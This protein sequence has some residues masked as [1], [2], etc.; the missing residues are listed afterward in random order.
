TYLSDVPVRYDPAALL[1]I[2]SIDGHRVHV[3]MS[4]SRTSVLCALSIV[5]VAVGVNAICTILQD[6]MTK[7]VRH[8]LMSVLPDQRNFRAIVLFKS[9]RQNSSSVRTA[10][11]GT[12]CVPTKISWHD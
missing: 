11:V 1:Q 2:I 12:T 10:N 9:I 6:S 7:N 8:V 4:N 5:E 3:A